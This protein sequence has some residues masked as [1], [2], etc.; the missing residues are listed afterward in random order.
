MKRKQKQLDEEYE[1]QQSM[2]IGSYSTGGKTGKAKTARI[3]FVRKAEKP[4][5]KKTK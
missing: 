3:G 2:T 1:E 5:A 4:V